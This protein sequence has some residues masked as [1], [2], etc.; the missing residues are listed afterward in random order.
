MNTYPNLL[1]LAF[2]RKNALILARLAAG[3]VMFPII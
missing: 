2:Q 3:L 1:T